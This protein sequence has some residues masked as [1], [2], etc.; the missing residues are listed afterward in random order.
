MSLHEQ[1]AQFPG[2]KRTNFLNYNLVLLHL[3]RK[4]NVSD[5]VTRNTPMLKD[6]KKVSRQSKIIRAILDG[7]M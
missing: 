7:I 5:T 6:R 1:K 4:M 2:C 3:C